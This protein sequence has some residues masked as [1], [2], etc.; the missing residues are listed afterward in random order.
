VSAFFGV[1]GVTAIFA[2]AAVPVRVLEAAKLVTA[3]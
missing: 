3:A 2:A 1:T